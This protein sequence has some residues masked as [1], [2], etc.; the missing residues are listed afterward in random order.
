MSFLDELRSKVIEAMLNKARD[1]RA[2]PADVIT[3]QAGI[4]CPHQDVGKELWCQVYRNWEDYQ[5]WGEGGHAE[6][7]RKHCQYGRNPEVTRRNRE[8]IDRRRGKYPGWLKAMGDPPEFM[9]PKRG[10]RLP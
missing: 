1:E 7:C 5:A 4:F 6:F 3:K 9:I 2:D 8:I 10:R